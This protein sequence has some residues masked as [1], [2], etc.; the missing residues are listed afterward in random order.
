MEC[1]CACRWSTSTSAEKDIAYG[2]PLR[3][4]LVDIHTIGAGGG[5]IARITRAGLLQVGPESAGAHPGPIAY[6]R[7]GNAVTVTDANLLLGRLNPDRLTG[8][9]HSAPMETIAA[10]LDEQI[11]APLGLDAIAAAAAVA[12]GYSWA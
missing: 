9:A 11:G 5:S 1:R 2:V 4:P 12:A 10:A 6:G 8:V 3:V 7:G